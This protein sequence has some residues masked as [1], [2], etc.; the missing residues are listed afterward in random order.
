MT[1]F[2]VQANEFSELPKNIQ[3]EIR[4]SPHFEK[5]QYDKCYYVVDQYIGY[6]LAIKEPTKASLMKTI[7]ELYDLS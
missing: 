6:A 4:K 1:T 3:D 2:I 5:Q 7:K